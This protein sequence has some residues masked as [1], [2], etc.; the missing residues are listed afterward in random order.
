MGIKL[1]EAMKEVKHT[2]RKM[3]DTKKKVAMYCADLDCMQPTYGSADE[4]KKKVSEWLQMYHDL[5]L[6]LTDLK[7]NIQNT[8]LNTNVTIK[9]GDNNITRS[10]AEWVIRRREIIDLEIAV[11]SSLSDR[12][13]ADKSL[14]VRG[15]LDDKKVRDAR[16]R[17]YFDASERDKNLETLKTEKESIDKALE[18]INA[19]TELLVK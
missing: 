13:L 11:Y 5:A 8:N 9:V 12:G 2:L 10:I 7:R 4:Q 1:I 14:L 18:I 17:F 3:E 15:G 16:V 6:N 19:T